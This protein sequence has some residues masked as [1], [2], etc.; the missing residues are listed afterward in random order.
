MIYSKYRYTIERH[1]DASA[2]LKGLDENDRKS[3]KLQTLTI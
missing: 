3:L 2:S 1:Q